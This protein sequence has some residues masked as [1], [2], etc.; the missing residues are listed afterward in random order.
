MFKQKRKISSP[1]PDQEDT[2]NNLSHTRAQYT[3]MNRIKNNILK[4]TYGWMKENN[5]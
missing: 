5:K 4:K 3:M 1:W 2:A